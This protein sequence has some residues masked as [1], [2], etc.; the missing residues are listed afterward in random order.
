MAVELN[1]DRTVCFFDSLYF[2][3]F[4]KLVE[5]DISLVFQFVRSEL[6]IIAYRVGSTSYAVIELSYINKIAVD[7]I[8]LYLQ[9]FLIL[10]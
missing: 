4:G 1:S 7:F 10:I 9:F 8:D 3:E 5:K 6:G 2:T